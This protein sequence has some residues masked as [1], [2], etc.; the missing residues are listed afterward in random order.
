[1]SALYFSMSRDQA[2]S[3]PERHSLTKRSSLHALGVF[4]DA[5]VSTGVIGWHFPRGCERRVAQRSR[6][7]T[8]PERQDGGCRWS[9]LRRPECQDLPGIS[10]VDSPR[11]SLA[12]GRKAFCAVHS[13]P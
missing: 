11:E 9:F 12:R 5:L 6:G 13:P 7:R 10:W 1:M 8:A 3:L 4:F 2:S